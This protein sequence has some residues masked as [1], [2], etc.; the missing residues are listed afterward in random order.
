M[1]FSANYFGFDDA[2]TTDG[3][4]TGDRISAIPFKEMVSLSAADFASKQKRFK[5]VIDNEEN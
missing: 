4:R 1:I 3:E 2:A 5:E